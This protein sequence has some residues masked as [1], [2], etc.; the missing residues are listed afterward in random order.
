MMSKFLVR[1]IC[2]CIHLTLYSFVLQQSMCVIQ[3]RVNM[4]QFVTIIGLTMS[5]S[6]QTVI[7][8]S[9]VK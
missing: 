3:P 6:V 1:H 9:T 7:Q 4:V 8:E 5:V 2:L